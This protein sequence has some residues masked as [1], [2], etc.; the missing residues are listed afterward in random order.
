MVL[1]SG[2]RLGRC[3]VLLLGKPGAGNGEL[4]S[5]EVG[6]RLSGG[7]ARRVSIACILLLDEPTEGLDADSEAQ[8]L[9]DFSISVTTFMS[10]FWLFLY[11]TRRRVD[12]INLTAA[13]CRFF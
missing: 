8:V 4:K 1:T 2:T 10:K 3:E 7:L 9:E 13:L 12:S 5:I 6:T 11:T